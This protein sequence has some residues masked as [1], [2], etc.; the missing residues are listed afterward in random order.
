[1]AAI[2]WETEETIP[3]VTRKE[4]TMTNTLTAGQSVK[5]ESGNDEFSEVV[6]RGKLWDVIQ[7]TRV[8][9]RDA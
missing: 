6:P 9:E 5:M 8:V 2:E 4:A 1:M 7:N 3:A